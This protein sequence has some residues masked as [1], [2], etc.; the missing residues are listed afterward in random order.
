MWA[1]DAGCRAR[2]LH[3]SDHYDVKARYQREC[4][5]P[6]PDPLATNLFARLK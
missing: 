3:P 2:G 1:G 4:R 6:G 5:I